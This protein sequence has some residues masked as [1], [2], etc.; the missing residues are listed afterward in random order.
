MSDLESNNIR[1][2]VDEAV[3]F[4]ERSLVNDCVSPAA[5]SALNGV[6][7]EAQEV[8]DIIN[9]FPTDPNAIPSVVR[10]FRKAKGNPFDHQDPPAEKID[11]VDFCIPCDG[12]ELLARI[13]RPQGKGNQQLP[14]LAYYHGGG[15]VLG[16]IASYDKALAQLAYQSSVIVISVEYRLAPE[17]PFPGAV[18]DAFDSFNWICRE[19]KRF[20]IDPARIAIGGDSAGGNL[21]AV[22]CMNNRDRGLAE[23]AFQLLIYPS[24]IGNDRSESRELFAENLLLTKTALKW[25]HDH[26]ISKEQQHDP[27]FN[28]LNASDF[29]NLPPAFILTCGFDPLRDEGQAYA[30]ELRLN[31][32][33]VR[34]SCYTDMYH[35]FFNFGI[36]TQ[37]QAAISECAKIM[38]H[39]LYKS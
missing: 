2:I 6:N 5:K 35:G 11:K 25:F 23:P 16:D 33:A 3:I 26:Y 14:A 13:Y 10:E 20:N 29:S 32:V 34:H 19:A 18:Q 1:A 37:S 27:R 28:L 31:G 36:L 9:A 24:I 21:A 8:L 30:N 38:A 17:T 39:F 15:F 7:P 4:G 12:H 22:V